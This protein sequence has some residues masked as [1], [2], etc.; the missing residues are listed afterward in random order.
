[1]GTDIEYPKGGKGK[2][3]FPFAPVGEGE[4][5]VQGIVHSR[6]RIGKRAKTALR[7]TAIGEAIVCQNDEVEFFGKFVIV[8]FAFHGRDS[9]CRSRGK[10]RKMFS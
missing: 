7:Q 4:F 2:H 3:L 8:K 1:M 10:N 9:L 6:I 5:G